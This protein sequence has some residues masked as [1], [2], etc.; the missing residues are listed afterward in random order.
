MHKE[1]NVMY[2]I[3]RKL[4]QPD[5]VIDRRFEF[6]MR[7]AETLGRLAWK[8]IESGIEMELKPDSTK[9]TTA[10]IALN[11]R[12]IEMVERELP[13]DLVWGEE[14]SN[15]EKGN[16]DEADSHWMWL[17]DPIDG[18]SGFW[19]SYN[20]GH[21]D[22]S[23]TNILITGFAPSETTPTMAVISNPFHRNPSMIFTKNNR[24]LYVCD[25]IKK[26]ILLRTPY[27]YP[28]ITKL[29][30]VQR[31][32]YNNWDGSAPDLRAMSNHM[33]VARYVKHPL[34]L[35]SVALGDVDISA[36]PAPSNPHDIAPGA[37]IVHNAQ[38]SVMT[39][40]QTPYEK[41]DWR[42][43][44]INGIVACQNE[45]LATELILSLAA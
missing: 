10:D 42:K 44:P 16:L 24:S 6:M 39:F 32:E 43:G 29:S 1:T 11:N 23:S 20:N 26:P 8:L 27:Q 34:F 37:A 40:D 22:D 7:S 33:P 28:G 30:Q 38:G 5:K 3:E 45:Q 17:I 15:S 18:T 35:G 2:T 14:C 12:F 4:K 21:F 13:D 9:V 36:F 31:Y 19:R 41:V 25:A